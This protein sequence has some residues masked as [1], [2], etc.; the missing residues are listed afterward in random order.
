MMSVHKKLMQARIQLQNTKLSKSGHNK[1]AGYTYFELSDFLPT[2][3]N[4][5]NDL[6]LCGVITFREDLATLTIVD[7]DKPES[8]IEIHSPM[9]EANLKGCHPIQNLGAVETYTRRYLWVTALEIVEH[10]ILDATTGSE[11]PSKAAK[12]NFDENGNVKPG[13]VTPS[14]AAQ[15][16]D[17]LDAEAQAFLQ[18][19]A[20]EIVSELDDGN[21]KSAHGLFY[22]NNLDHDEKIALWSRLDSKQRSTIKAFQDK[23]V[24]GKQPHIQA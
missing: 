14:V 6:G 21:V 10:D 19:I 22:E 24:N 7:V 2:V 18:D 11:K 13:N 9:K 20:I 5:F 12:S 1:F 16:W 8:I 3:Q 23:L 15:E 17:K 4:I